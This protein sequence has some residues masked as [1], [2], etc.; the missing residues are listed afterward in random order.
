MKSAKPVIMAAHVRQ[1]ESGTSIHF[2]NNK[3]KMIIRLK[4]A[5]SNKK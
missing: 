4:P 5:L 2:T 1:T 3:A